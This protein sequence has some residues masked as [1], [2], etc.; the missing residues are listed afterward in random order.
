M[1][2]KLSRGERNR[3]REATGKWDNTAGPRNYVWEMSWVLLKIRML[4]MQLVIKS[5]V[6]STSHKKIIMNIM[7]LLGEDQGQCC[8]AG[9]VQGRFKG[10]AQ[11]GIESDLLNQ[12]NLGEEEKSCKCYSLQVYIY[13]EIRM[14]LSPSRWKLI[15]V[16]EFIIINF[17]VIDIGLF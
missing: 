2:L 7:P 4:N 3:E 11:C 17:T 15:I 14:L 12:T 16:F 10:K 6:K 9:W 13:L 5:S 1:D 8:V